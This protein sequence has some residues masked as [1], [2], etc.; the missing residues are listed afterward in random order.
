[1]AG[2]SVVFGIHATAPFAS[3]MDEGSVVAFQV[4]S[5]DPERH[6]GWQVRAVGSLGPAV[7]PDELAV[8]GAVVPEPWTIGAALE[9]VLQ[10]ELEVIGGWVV[11]ASE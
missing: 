7:T 8:A 5:F 11:E 6:C 9:R 3:E 2:E 4:D 10:L 1:V